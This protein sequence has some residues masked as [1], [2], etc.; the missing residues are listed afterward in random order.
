MNVLD[1][2]I[3]GTSAA[4]STVDQLAT[5]AGFAMLER[6][7]NAVDAAIAA[8]FVLTVTA[9]HMC[10][11]GGD[12]FALVHVPGESEPA[13]L[14]ASG[15]SGSGAMLDSLAGH[16]AMPHRGT[17]HASPIP[18]AVDGL[19]TLHERWGTLE[20]ADLLSPAIAAAEGGF[21]A[22]PLLARSAAQLESC[23][24][25]HDFANIAP[26]DRI[27]R[28][29][30][31]RT[32]RAIAT[33]GRNGFYGGEFGQALVSLGAGIYSDDDLRA[34][35][36]EWVTP[37]RVGVWGHD[38]W[39]VPPN[40]QGYLSLAIC[41]IAEQLGLP[42]D[43]DDP[44]WAHLMIEATRAASFDRTAVL[45]EAAEGAALLDPGRLKARVDRISPDGRVD[46]RGERYADGGT[47]HLCTADDSGMAVSL[48]QSNARDFGAHLVVG[49]TGIFLHNRGIGF[50]LDPEHPAAYGPR[51][52]PP[53][54]L[55][56]AL[57]SRPDGRLRSVV[58]TMG[59][60]SQP[61]IVAQI[62][63]RLL[64]S[65]Q[66][67]GIA[68]GAGRFVLASV[69]PATAFE[70]WDGHGEVRAVIEPSVNGW[71]APLEALGHSVTIG[72]EPSGFG[73]AHLID[74]P[75]PDQP[76]V[77]AATDPRALIGLALAN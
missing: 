16:S 40:S 22:S 59:G 24:V 37:L 38:L 61:H 49:D 3:Y 25:G 65:A 31:A 14:N 56:P 53:H 44:Q 6:G 75:D 35:N 42:V 43:P 70:T 67:P 27:T 64:H 60:D 34:N 32:L 76:S 21:A 2:T 19:V 30:I 13:A 62:V 66:T 74:R 68:V 7:G 28:P 18:G 15:R 12:L 58:G 41:A 4:V 9:Q 26:G 17:V 51:R 54:T 50:R 23:A 47:M 48:I 45:H 10:G 57:I 5:Q 71:R 73:H 36:A 52:R 63:A 33:S 1:H 29:G 39:T 72:T 55:S 46:W 11:L 77:A 8:N 20:L 69:D